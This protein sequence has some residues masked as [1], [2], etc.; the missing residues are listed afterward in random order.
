MTESQVWGSKTLHILCENSERN[1]NPKYLQ[2]VQAQSVC[3]H[4]HVRVCV[5]VCVCHVCM[6]AQACTIHAHVY[7]VKTV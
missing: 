6:C 4:V 7:F 2:V 3:V 1:K 5:H